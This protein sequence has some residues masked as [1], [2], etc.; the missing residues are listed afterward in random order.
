M[1]QRTA[2]RW[3]RRLADSGKV[4]VMTNGCFD[5]L[6]RGHAEYLN[7]ARELGDALLVA[8]NTDAS[9]AVIKGPARP[10]VPEADRVYLVASLESVDAV[11]LFGT[12]EQTDACP[13][14]RLLRPEIYAKGGDYSEDT[15]NRRER[16]LLQEL[17]CRI[18][19]VPFVA[20]LSTTELIR[21]VV[22]LT[23]EGTHGPP[24]QRTPP[25]IE[26]R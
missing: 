9:V 6:H 8:V 12:P 26:D 11:V 5:L 17:G 1:L 13:L 2:V 25:S 21:R 10:V 19:F 24:R 18:E 15:I 4:L 16:R 3:R 20:G 7:R 14:L 22:R 23:E